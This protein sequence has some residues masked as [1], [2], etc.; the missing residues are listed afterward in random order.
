MGPRYARPPLRPGWGSM[1]PRC[2]RP[3]PATWMGP[4][5]ARPLP[6]ATWLDAYQT[7]GG[8]KRRGKDRVRPHGHS[9]KRIP[10]S[11]SVENHRPSRGLAPL[12][13]RLVSSSFSTGL[14]AQWV[15]FSRSFQG[16]WSRVFCHCAS[17]G[18]RGAP[19]IARAALP[20]LR[21]W[22][23]ACSAGGGR[24]RDGHAWRE[25][26]AGRRWRRRGCRGACRREEARSRRPRPLSGTSSWHLRGGIRI[27]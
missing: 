27:T 12:G 10:Q 13:P 14:G 22:R 16:D 18:A 6:P 1:G 8:R 4:R 2:A 25:D 9:T 5:C 24:L 17:S 26:T 11:E 21:L 3:P 15:H 23:G 19:A 7:D 20:S